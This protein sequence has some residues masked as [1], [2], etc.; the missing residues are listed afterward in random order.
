MKVVLL[1]NL[2]GKFARG[3]AEQVVYK[4]AQELKQAGHE[5]HVFSTGPLGFGTALGVDTVEEDGITVHRISPVNI[6]SYYHLGKLPKF[7]RAIWH[8]IDLFDV[9]TPNVIRKMLRVIEPDKVYTHNLKGM[10][11]RTIKSVTKYDHVHVLH[12]VQLITPSGLLLSN[13]TSSWEVAG[14]FA[15]WYRSV[16]QSYFKYVE[17]V[18]GQSQWIVDFHK[19]FGF[20]ENAKVEKHVLGPECAQPEA[21]KRGKRLLFVG[22]VETHKGIEVLVE[23]VQ[24]VRKED[25]G[26]TLTVVGGG[27]QYKKLSAQSQDG[28]TW[29]GKCAPAEV[30]QQYE[31]ADILVVPSIC[32]EN[33]PNVICE[34]KQHGLQIV[35]SDIGGISELLSSADRR[36]KAGSVDDLTRVLL[37]AVRG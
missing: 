17:T 11:M 6:I 3:G 27:A 12:D 4:Q 21:V 26:V 20:F 37:D 1:N 36:V 2:Y 13:Q 33:R 28:I 10:G 14:R 18:W 16:L 7:L 23:A 25:G 5:V 8:V 31:N 29:V 9:H 24:K 15:R 30:Q 35:A 22:Q 34:A 19:G 32:Y